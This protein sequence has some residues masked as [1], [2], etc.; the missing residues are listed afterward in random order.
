MR[1][2]RI[3]VLLLAAA[4]LAFGGARAWR[5]SYLELRTVE[6]E[7]NRRVSTDELVRASGLHRGVHLLR[8]ST[9]GTARKVESHP[10]IAKARVERIIPSTVRITVTERS[11]AAVVAIG[12]RT[13][14]ADREG[15]VLEEGTAPLVAILDLPRGEA[16]PGDRLSLPQ[17]EA[18]LDVAGRL[19]PDLRARLS[20]VRASS[21]D[22]IILELQGGISVLYG[23]NEQVEDKN[24]AIRALLA[25]A[26]ADGRQIAWIDVRVPSRPAV[27]PR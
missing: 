5:S 3:I 17:F 25:D 26:G 1:I 16:R 14:L 11:A 21:L 24:F 6:V 2:A 13:Y 9:E 18:A 12:P 22:R 19:P 23:V 4:G 8:M 15:V 7:G 27:R 10:W 20:S